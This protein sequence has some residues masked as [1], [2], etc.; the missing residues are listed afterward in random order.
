MRLL[1]EYG[2]RPTR[3]DLF[4]ASYN[5]HWVILQLL[6]PHGGS[7]V[8]SDYIEDASENGYVNVIRLLLEYGVR[9]TP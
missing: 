3:S 6:L 7:L 2:A 1:L 4:N 5:G 9:L 8:D